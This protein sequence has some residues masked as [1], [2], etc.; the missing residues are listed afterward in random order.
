MANRIEV[1]NI[2][3]NDHINNESMNYAKVVTKRVKRVKSF[4]LSESQNKEIIENYEKRKIENQNK[5][6]HINVIDKEQVIITLKE[7]NMRISNELD[8]MS[9]TLGIIIGKKNYRTK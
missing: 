2:N 7:K 5:N 8:R 4:E 3:P 1:P 6:D 9:R